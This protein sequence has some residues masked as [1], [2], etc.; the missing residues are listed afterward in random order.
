MSRQPFDAYTTPPWVVRRLLEAVAPPNQGWWLEPAAG[1][2]AII[3]AV[4]DAGKFGRLP[5]GRWIAIEPRQE[6]HASLRA[7]NVPESPVLVDARGVGYLKWEPETPPS[8]II[9]N[10]PYRIMFDFMQKALKDI[11]PQGLVAL[12]L[13]LSA[14][15]SEERR[16]WFAKHSPQVW[17]LPNRPSFVTSLKCKGCSW[18]STIAAGATKPD[19]CPECGGEIR[20][21]SSAFAEY[22]WFVWPPGCHNLTCG[23]LQWLARTPKDERLIPRARKL[24]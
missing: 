18:K 24:Q 23:R 1:D 16:E 15:A 22:A 12:L 19:G 13:P 5:Q 6:C 14:A 21:G 3:K 17:V 20:S 10:P 11:D 8:M 2:G 4:Q 9:T 7:L